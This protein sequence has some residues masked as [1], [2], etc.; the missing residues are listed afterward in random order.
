MSLDLAPPTDLDWY[1]G[2]LSRLA[3]SWGI[4]QWSSVRVTETLRHAS[5]G[6]P[7]D[8]GETFSIEAYRPRFTELCT[9]GWPWI[10]LSAV[11]LLDG[12]LLLSIEVPNMEPGG[13]RWTSV[14]LSGPSRRTLAMGG[15]LSG[16]L[17][18]DTS[19][20]DCP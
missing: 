18:G 19:P 5:V 14:N 17:P 3:P 8:V 15:C 4:P 20:P 2:Q 7:C 9:R 11:G 10:N 1:V 13:S 6:E 16:S 12:A